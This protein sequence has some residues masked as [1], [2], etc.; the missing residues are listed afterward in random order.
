MSERASGRVLVALAIGLT[1]VSTAGCLYKFSGGGGLPSHIN[2]VF[3][4]PVENETTQF[5]LT[6][7]LTT[8]LLDAARSRL[9][10][11]L[12]SEG[13]ADAVIRA[14]I[15]RYSDRALNFQAEENVGAQVFERQVSITARIE[16]V[17]LTR[18]E[19]LWSG[20][21][22]N[23]LGQYEPDTETEIAAQETALENLIQKV[24]DG[25]QSQW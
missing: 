17:D 15:T 25:A 1:A 21:A 4:P 6:E 5:T 23:G 12:A 14:S 18:N 22:V 24:V 10:V 7:L 20:P 9:G 16:I 19:I 8:G 3:V 13:D 2:T 11:Q